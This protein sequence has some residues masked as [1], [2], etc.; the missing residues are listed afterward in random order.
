MNVLVIG[1]GGR[2][3][4]LCWKL[5]QSPSVDHLFA[6][7][8]NPGIAK[9]ATRIAADPLDFTAIG[10]VCTQHDIDLV[11]VGPER[12]LIAGLADHLRE[13][14]IAVFGPSKHCAQI[15][16]SKAFAKKLMGE[17]GIPTAKYRVFT[18]IGGAES[19]IGSEFASGRP[20]VVKASGEALGKGVVVAES[21]ESAMLA[22]REMLVD[23]AFGD[24]GGEI[25]VEERLTG[26]ELSLMAICGGDNFRILPTS[27]DYKSAFEGGEGPNTGGM[28][29]VSPAP[30]FDDARTEQLGEVFIRPVLNRFAREGTP[31]FGALYCGLMLTSDG[32]K[33]L[34]YNA[35]F[36]D[37]ETQ[38]I[39]PRLRGDLGS[40]LLAASYGEPIPELA[41]SH[42]TCVAVVIA[43]RGYPGDYDRGTQ[44]PALPDGPALI[45]QAG[46][47][48][49]P[50]GLASSGGRVLTLAG[51]A[52][53]LVAAREIAYEAAKHFDQDSWHYRGDIGT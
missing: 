21:A 52:S 8:G 34:E 41:A 15:E 23:R 13:A 1:S 7:P 9:L 49:S 19:F 16:G 30:G 43:A 32:P 50:Q 45:F 47:Q 17:E 28:G 26:P 14:G 39:L 31:Y 20:V 4:A 24:A 38:A 18:E 29:A 22:A 46:T 51:V 12:P 33:A 42:D 53:D 27:R 11:V 5:A 44:L 2:E 10:S 36:G 25:V 3:H 35:R 37:P 48:E 6:A 40:A